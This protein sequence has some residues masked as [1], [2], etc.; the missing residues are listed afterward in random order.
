MYNND[1]N[2]PSKA[3]SYPA[4][5]EKIMEYKKGAE[6]I[7]LLARK[8]GEMIIQQTENCANEIRR[9]AKEEGKIKF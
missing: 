1:Y 7:I 2:Y 4:R 9:K 5:R 6:S 3:L 8:K